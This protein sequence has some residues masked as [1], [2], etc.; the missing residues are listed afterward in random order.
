MTIPNQQSPIGIFDSGVGGLSVLKAI[1]QLMPQ[2]NLLYVADSKYTPYGDR[3]RIFIESRV[4]AI[5]KFLMQQPVKLILV[6]CNTATA[7][8]IKLL[9]NQY[10]IPIVGLEP[11]LKPAAEYSPK[12][13]VGVIATQSTLQSE[14]YLDLK[15]RVAQNVQVTEKASKFLVEL[16]ESAE[17]ISAQQSQII[18]QELDIFLREKVDTLVLGCTH[19][20]F[21]TQKIA[22]IMGDQVKIFESAMPV[23]K[24]VLRKLQDQKNQQNT[25]GWI[26]YFS[27]DPQKAQHSFETIL[28]EKVELIHLNG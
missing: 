11:A 6:A 25:Q 1:R 23:A 15:I 2:E 8:A 5:A 24:E 21:L 9:R 20:P 18:K 17:K 13:S 3:E 14:K 7:A 27:T 26:K 12:K 16:V 19:Y 4:A 10:A 28:A 22:E